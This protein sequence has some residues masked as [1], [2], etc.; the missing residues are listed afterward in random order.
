MSRFMGLLT[1]SFVWVALAWSQPAINALPKGGQVAQGAVQFSQSAQQLQ[2]TQSS[3]RAA[4]NWQSFDIGAA[5][6]VNVVQPSAQAVLL[7]RVGGTAPSQIFGQ[8]QANGKVILVN[9]NG[10]VFGQDGSVS[11]AAF[12]ASTLNISDADFMAGNERY[13]RDG[14]T[15]A[16]VNRGLIQAAPGGYVALLGASVSNEGQ[17]VAPQGNV[18][19][20]AADAVTLPARA[21]AMPMGS[22]GR[23]RLELTPASINAAVANQ[24]GGTI[25]TEGGQ[26]YL[27]AAALNQAMATVLQSGSIDTTGGQGGQ[28]HVLADG[29]RIRVDGQIKANSTNGTAGGDIYIG[30]DKDTNVLAAVGDV[31]GAQLE[32]K[33]GFVETSGGYLATDGVSVKAAEWL[34]DPYNITIASSL[35]SGTAYSSNYTSVA[36]SV[37]LASDIVANLNAGTSVSIQTGAGG[38]SA[39]DISVNADIVKASGAMASLT[40]TAHR[41]VLL[42]S[43]IK[44]TSSDLNINLNALTGKVTGAGGLAAGSGGLITVN[45]ATN[46]ELSGIIES[47]ALLKTGAGQTKL[48]AM[49]GGTNT[50][51]GG[52]TISQGTLLLGNGNGR[53]DRTAGAGAITL[54]DV[55]TGSSNVSLLLEKGKDASQDSGKLTRTVTVT[56][57][58]TGTA[59]LGG[60]VG[61]AGGSGWTAFGGALALNKNIIF[62]DETGDRTSLDGLITGTGHITAVSG[63]SIMASPFQNTW[64]GNYT[65]N[66]GTVLQLNSDKALSVNNNLINNG[67][68]RLNGGATLHINALTGSGNLNLQNLGVSGNS[69]LNIG[70]GNGGGVFSGTLTQ[71]SGVL[72]LVKNGTGTQT[73]SGVNTYTGTTTI[74]GGNLQIGNAGT[75]GTLGTGAVTNNAML[76]FNRSNDMT[77]ANAISGSGGLTQSG[78]G[79]TTLTASNTYTGTTTIT[80]GNLQIGNAGTSGTLGTGA[81]TNNATLTFNRSNDMTVA[82]AISGSGGLTQSGGGTTTLTAANT[83][84]GTTLVSGGGLALG[85]VNALQNSTLDT[86]TSGAQQVTFTAVG[87]NTYNIGALQGADDLAAGANSISAGA[88]NAST[89]YSGVVSGTGNFSKVGNGSQI[90]SGNNSYSGTTTV[91]GGTLQIGSGGGTGSLG[92]GAVS[93]SNSSTLRF[94]RNVDTV[95]ANAVS[96]SGNLSATITGAGSDFDLGANVNLTHTGSTINLN[97][98]GAITQSTGSVAATS[99]LMT[100]GENIGAAN[101]HIE[102]SVGSV[103]LDSAGD[104]FLTEANNI[105]VSARTTANGNIHISTTNGTLNAGSFNGVSGITAG[106]TGNI[107]LSGNTASGHG[108]NLSSNVSASNGDVTLSG[109]TSSS[110]TGAAPASGV[111]SSARVSANNI[112]MTATAAGSTGHVLG[113]YGAG[114][115]F[116]ASGSLALS[117]TSDSATGNGFYSFTGAMSSGTGITINGTSNNGQAVGLDA[118][119]SLTNTSGDIAIT[120]EAKGSNN[121]AIGLRGSSITNNGGSIRLIASKGNVFTNSVNGAGGNWGVEAPGAPLLNTLRSNGTGVVEIFA[122]TLAADTGAIDGKAMTIHQNANVG[123]LVKTAGAGNV[124]APKVINAGTGDVRVAAGAVLSAGDGSGG[125]V[126]TVAGNTVSQT[127]ATTPGK[128]YVYSGRAIG[129]GVL[130][131]FGSYFN[132]LH[133]NGSTHDLNAAFGSAFGATL[134]GESSTQVLFREAVTS[135]PGFALNMAGL[136]LSKIYGAA[137]PDA[138][139]GLSASYAGPQMLTNSVAGVGGSHVFGLAAADA[140]A[141]LSGTRAAGENASTTPYAFSLTSTGLNTSVS[142]Q[143]GLLILKKTLSAALQGTVSK[144]YDGTD[145]ANNLSNANFALT[146]WVTLNGVTDGANVTQTSGS[147]ASKEVANNMGGAGSVS[148]DLSA[149][150]FVPSGTTLLSNYTLPTVATGNVGTIT[151]APLTVQVGSSTMFVTQDPQ[152]AADTGIRYEGLKNG[153]LPNDVLGALTPN[154]SGPATPGVG[155]YSSVYGLTSAPTA[156]NYA[157]T[158]QP[159]SLNVLAADKL[160]IRLGGR[161]ATYGDVTAANAGHTSAGQG[162]SALYCVGGVNCNTISTLTMSD[163]GGG[164]W[165]ATDTLGSSIRLTTQVNTTGQTS[166]AGFLNAG[167]H[168]YAVGSWSVQG[169]QNFT[170]LVLAAGALVITPKTLSLNAANVFKVYDGTKALAGMRL[171]PGGAMPGDDVGMVSNGGSFASKNAGSQAFTLSGLQLEGVDRG[172]YSFVSGNVSGTGLITPRQIAASFGALDKVYDGNTTANLTGGSL[173]GVIL[174]DDVSV[175]GASAAFADPNVARDASGQVLAK[176]VQMADVSLGGVDGANYQLNVTVGTARITPKTVTST[177]LAEDKVYDGLTSAIASAITTGVIGTDEVGVALGS[178]NFANKNVARNANGQVTDQTVTVTGLRLTGALAGNYELSNTSATDVAKISPK[179][180]APSA[181]VFDKVYDGQA[182]AVLSGLGGIGLLPGDAVNFAAS[183]AQFASPNVARN[184][185]GQVLAQEVS[186]KGLRLMGQDAGNYVLQGEVDSFKTMATIEPRPLSIDAKALDKVYDGTTDVQLKWSQVNGWVAQERL[187]FSARA[188]FETPMVG[189]NKSV[190]VHY[191]LTDGVNG[192]S[193]SNYVLAAQSLSAS[194]L[195]SQVNKS[196]QKEITP[197]TAETGANKVSF[198]RTGSAAAMGVQPSSAEA[199]TEAASGAATASAAC[200]SDRVENCDCDETLVVGVQLCYVPRNAPGTTAERGLNN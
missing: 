159:G 146:G 55:N 171:L 11:A 46:G 44:T 8:L 122:G 150:H 49:S 53:Y 47:G 32:S 102:T 92:V 66:T 17:I 71:S 176:S 153:E 148:A 158:V 188:A 182:G 139:V 121:Q 29:G 59:T 62:S 128:T 97:V 133:Y 77:V 117:G 16:I 23:I 15:G 124:T 26:V 87:T 125:Q 126:L 191:S 123:V 86:G 21:V 4:V 99:L 163:L 3:D 74:S 100:A 200:L 134:L 28:V 82:N 13:T 135:A 172:N 84:T 80:G 115:Q 174:G 45:T 145:A 149:G 195:S 142:G 165:Q 34:L 170:D 138:L 14:A 60:V 105:I 162:I 27:Q 164:Q 111:Y 179:L 167:N 6:K 141:T 42:S 175:I 56:S 155:N 120:G 70:G 5:A 33:G 68:V 67:T 35:P 154:Y 1:A 64:T 38:A 186:V 57:N 79:T 69:T 109:T 173:S 30:R 185:Q 157:V 118:N 78:G 161:S 184:S 54:G 181:A 18:Y 75:T 129:T 193:A 76:T 198:V 37:I 63:R 183:G 91:S 9:P 90:L 127:H 116:I 143:A 199:A 197:L 119:V 19:M 131:R 106:G 114:G 189:V 41:D 58:G 196:I 137:D 166:A 130:S 43:S 81:V 147:Y 110:G 136:N 113:Y 65:V 107:S 103:A 52:I 178:A 51:A 24:K 48:S 132:T 108:L 2:I 168:D 73:L 156:A 169:G 96:G 190:S 50:F 31:S 101:K 160:L 85:H 12:T 22:S 61:S 39:G 192:A 140:L 187:G 94:V 152:L 112:T 40:L 36:D 89:T 20:A 144:V 180:L 93:L 104:Q 98:A 7:N 72:S 95:L 25:V 151:R 83:F 10:M 88:N 194:I 177:V